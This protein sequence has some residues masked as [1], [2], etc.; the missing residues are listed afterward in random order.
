MQ[1]HS[2]DG[3]DAGSLFVHPFSSDE[4]KTFQIKGGGECSKAIMINF[5]HMNPFPCRNLNLHKGIK[6]RSQSIWGYKRASP[7]MCLCFTG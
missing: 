6:Y 7:H 4:K 3:I 1:K 5:A 2:S